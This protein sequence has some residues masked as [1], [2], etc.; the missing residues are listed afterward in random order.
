MPDSLYQWMDIAYLRSFTNRMAMCRQLLII[1]GS[2][3]MSSPHGL[4]ICM[5]V[6]VIKPLPCIIGNN[7]ME[8]IVPSAGCLQKMLSQQPIEGSLDLP[9]LCL[10]LHVDRCHCERCV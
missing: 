9:S 6:L 3:D 10:A 5:F 4:L 7:G 1:V 2:A 8:L